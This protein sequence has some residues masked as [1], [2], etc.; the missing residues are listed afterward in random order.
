MKD[1]KRLCADCACLIEKGKVW[2]CDEMWGR[3]CEE[4]EECPEEFSEEDIAQ[5][6]ALDKVKI[7]HGAT[8]TVEEKTERKSRTVKISDEKTQLFKDIAEM[9]E[10][11][12]Y[13]FEIAKENKLFE[14]KI[15][16]G[17]AIDLKEHRK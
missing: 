12:G 5:V 10:N 8:A 2:C 1:Y 3:P 17:I 4:V 7:Q 15:G 9:L 13:S 6:D 14:V 16:K 11:K